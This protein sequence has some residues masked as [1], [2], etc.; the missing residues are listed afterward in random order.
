MNSYE[1]FAAKNLEINF[2][3]C[4]TLGSLVYPEVQRTFGFWWARL[5][6]KD[7]VSF[8]SSSAVHQ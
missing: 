3:C 2:L 8:S 6:S 4:I 5:F 7:D 1:T